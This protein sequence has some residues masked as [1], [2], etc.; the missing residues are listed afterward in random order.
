MPEPAAPAEAER[1][2]LPAL[3]PRTSLPRR[4][5]G[6]CEQSERR[7]RTANESMQPQSFYMKKR[8]LA[9]LSASQFLRAHWQKKPLLACNAL[10]EYVSA[11]DRDQ[12][13][14]LAG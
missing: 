6:L 8:Y 14:E 5:K 7:S 4:V 11:I 1:D 12:L 9:G 10:A 13:I 3:T 2:L